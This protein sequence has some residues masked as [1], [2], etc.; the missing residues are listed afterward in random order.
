VVEKKEEPKEKVASKKAAEI[1][2][3]SI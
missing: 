2:K 3:D 1:E